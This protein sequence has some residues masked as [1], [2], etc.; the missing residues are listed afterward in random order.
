MRKCRCMKIFEGEELDVCK[1]LEDLYQSG[2]EE[3]REEGREEGIALA[4]KIFKL[5]REGV[6]NGEIAAKCNLL[7]SKVEEILA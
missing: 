3:G 4:K 1:A 6:T 2:C 7:V 5:Q